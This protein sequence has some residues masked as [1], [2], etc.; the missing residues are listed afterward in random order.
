MSQDPKVSVVITT[1]NQAP[2]IGLA[3]ETVFAQTLQPD[4]VVVVDDGSTDETAERIAP[5]RDRIVYLRQSNQG[6]AHARN[7]GIRRARGDLLAFLDGDDLWEPEK[8]ALQVAAA[9]EHSNSGLI[10]V[11]GV[12]F[13]AA[14]IMRESMF[15]TPIAGLFN[16]GAESVSLDASQ[17]FLRENV[18]WTTSQVMIPARVLDTVGLSDPQLAL[19]S[20][21]D[22]YLR[23]AERYPVTFVPRRLMRWR[24]HEASASGPAILRELRWGEEGLRMLAKHVQEVSGDRRRI[25]RAALR[26][27]VFMLTQAAYYRA[28]AGQRELGLRYLWRFLPWSRVSAAPVA[29]LLAAYSPAWLK[30]WL[31]RVARTAL[32]VRR[33]A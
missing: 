17:Y 5:F 14:G 7:S 11:D 28:E 1:Y 27:Q 3:L 24:Y 8:L 20:D 19:V 26:S 31:A 6:V 4:E 33:S 12:Q 23:I 16:G 29:F 2:Y 10:A 22:L 15:P 21:W 30:R 9:S 13:A 18:I 32:K 25:V